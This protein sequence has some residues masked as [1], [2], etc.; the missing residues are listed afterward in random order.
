MS[1]KIKLCGLRRIEDVDAVNRLLP[2]YVGF[3][4]ASKSKRF[5]TVE[6]ACKLRES[7]QESIVS[8]G[9]FKDNSPKEVESALDSGAVSVI[10]LHGREDSEYILHFKKKYGVQVIKAFGI[11][12]EE[13]VIKANESI[14]DMVLLDAPGGGTGTAFDHSL[15][16]KMTRPY[17]LAGGLDPE[18]VGFAI[19]EY[20]PYAVDVSSGIETNGYKDKAKMEAFVKAVRERK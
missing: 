14:S 6:E 1:S 15:L 10:Q 2:E 9:V 17:F 13:D 20:Q 4:F 12:S 7:L 8:V 3:V 19:D 11:E 16:K 18:N 5:I